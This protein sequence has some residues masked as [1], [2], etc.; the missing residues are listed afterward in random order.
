VL[1]RENSSSGRSSFHLDVSLIN[2]ITKLRIKNP[3]SIVITQTY[4]LLQAIDRCCSFYF[5]ARTVLSLING[6]AAAIGSFVAYTERAAQIRAYNRYM[7][8]KQ[9]NIQI[10]IIKQ[11]PN[12][13]YPNRQISLGEEE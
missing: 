12:V 10:K 1:N 3:S 5:D 6:Y 11:Q 7:I 2:T 8:K 4:L 9:R 13:L